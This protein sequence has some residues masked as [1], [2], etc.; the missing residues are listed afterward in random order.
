M[1]DHRK[2]DVINRVCSQTM[3]LAKI[4][5]IDIEVLVMVLLTKPFFSHQIDSIYVKNYVA[6]LNQV[7]ELDQIQKKCKNSFIVSIGSNITNKSYK[8]LLVDQHVKSVLPSIGTRNAGIIFA[9]NSFSNVF[10][11]RSNKEISMVD[12]EGWVYHVF[13]L[14]LLQALEVDNSDDEGEIEK[15]YCV[16]NFDL[17]GKT[18][19][20]PGTFKV[21]SKRKGLIKRIV[22]SLLQGGLGRWTEDSIIKIMI[23]MI[24]YF[25]KIGAIKF[26]EYMRILHFLLVL[27]LK[28]L[29]GVVKKRNYKIVV[30]SE[31][32]VQVKV[33]EG[34]QTTR[35]GKNK[36]LSSCFV[37]PV[38]VAC[39]NPKCIGKLNFVDDQEN[40]K[41]CRKCYNVIQNFGAHE[42]HPELFNYVEGNLDVS[43]LCIDCIH[44]ERTVFVRMI[45]PLA[46][47][48]KE[49]KGNTLNMDFF[50]KILD[51]I[52]GKDR[53]KAGLEDGKIKIVVANREHAIDYIFDFPE[54]LDDFFESHKTIDSP[55][56]KNFFSLVILHFEVLLY[57]DYS[58]IQVPGLKGRTQYSN[59]DGQII[60]LIN[61]NRLEIYELILVLNPNYKMNFE[62]FK[63]PYDKGIFKNLI[64]T[65][66]KN[67]TKE[68]KNDL[69]KYCLIA[70]KIAL[71]IKVM[72]DTISF[73]FNGSEWKKTTGGNF[74]EKENIP[75]HYFYSIFWG[76]TWRALEEKLG[77]I[78]VHF[79]IDHGTLILIIFKDGIKIFSL[80]MQE[81]NHYDQLAAWGKTNGP[82]GIGDKVLTF[83]IMEVQGFEFLVSI[84]DF[85]QKIEQKIPFTIA[86]KENMSKEKKEL[87]EQ[88]ENKTNLFQ[89]SPSPLSKIKK[90]ENPIEMV[91]SQTSRYPFYLNWLASFLDNQFHFFKLDR[92]M[93]YN[94][95]NNNKNLEFHNENII[96][97]NCFTL[98]IKEK[99]ERIQIGYDIGLIKKNHVGVLNFGASS[100]LS[101]LIQSFFSFEDLV[102]F[103][104]EKEYTFDFPF[105]S[106]IAKIVQL[107][108]NINSRLPIISPR[109]LH[110][111]ISKSFKD[112]Q[113]HLPVDVFK[114]IIQNLCREMNFLSNSLI[115]D[116]FQIQFL[117]Q[118]CCLKCAN[119]H[120]YGNS[121]FFLSFQN[122]SGNSLKSL[123]E[124]L[125]NYFNIKE[126]VNTFCETCQSTQEF[127]KSSTITSLPKILTFHFPNSHSSPNE[128]LRVDLPK[129]ISFNDPINKNEVNF[130]LIS[131]IYSSHGNYF[132]ERNGRYFFDEK[133]SDNFQNSFPHL[134]FYQREE[135]E[136]KEINISSSETNLLKTRIFDQKKNKIQT[137]KKIFS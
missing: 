107:Y 69:F 60:S 4:N 19:F 115:E 83:K 134:T 109:Y 116:S 32:S 6:F 21:I 98:P 80:E 120:S 62:R 102:R 126:K 103:F 68:Q 46:R 55:F 7:L 92:N 23:A 100:F 132:A 118:Y 30:A 42:P 128:K 10:N 135:L 27:D 122:K 2:D 75:F 43:Q 56:K 84:H 61:N 94:T 13:Y 64:E 110:H 119:E 34:F 33:E 131:S 89:A 105:L 133:I 39:T 40:K 95:K 18:K 50:N 121:K 3:H 53:V 15:L 44:L 63:N 129:Q 36:K 104:N 5:K 25:L 73:G 54:F 88:I 101:S 59:F 114:F 72:L 87:L 17:A 91:K 8:A 70:K 74:S 124:L 20:V 31:K 29:W 90:E 52:F 11:L 112:Q 108:T 51:K 127:T 49:M 125:F 37:C 77:S 86:Q 41:C 24:I 106:S 130:V 99:Y 111:L 47:L 9:K 97:V 82:G 16:G 48:S 35:D 78:Y 28:A 67:N 71:K 81:H 45:K 96:D 58:I 22:S 137:N 93:H 38:E 76:K 12:P 117:E 136:R 26:A 1:I 57:D 113:E 66:E 123:K 85:H 65:I 14:C 79:M